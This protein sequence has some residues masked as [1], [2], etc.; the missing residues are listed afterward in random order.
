MA[1]HKQ[2]GPV[3]EGKT[4]FPLPRNG[5]HKR[6]VAQAIHWDAESRARCVPGVRPCPRH[7]PDAYAKEASEPLMPEP[8]R[9]PLWEQ[10]ARDYIDGQR[11]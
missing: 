2:N 1:T 7:H 3:R 5:K 8:H 9:R 11:A 6:L 10:E 4:R